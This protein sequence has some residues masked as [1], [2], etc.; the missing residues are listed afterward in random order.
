MEMGKNATH[1][2]RKLLILAPIVALI[3]NSGHVLGCN[4]GLHKRSQPSA[5]PPPGAPNRQLGWGDLNILHTTDS[6]GH[7]KSEQP[8]PNYSG[9][10][11][12]FHSF[13]R[14][15]KEKA[16]Q[17]GVDLLVVDSGD[18][19][20]GNGLSDA[21]PYVHPGT[22]RGSTSSKIF[23]RVPYDIL[24]IG[25]HELYDL[26]IAQDMHDNFAPSWKGSY[27]T[28]NVNITTSGTS[29]PLGSRYRKFV[30]EQGR[31]VTAFGIIFHFTGN[32]N[33]TTVQP[34]SELVSE[35]WFKEAIRD[36]P[37][38]FLLAGHMGIRDP[39]WKIVLDSIRAI[40][41]DVPVTILGGHYHIRDCQQLDDRSM[42]LASGR[43][44]ETLGW[45]SLSGLDNPG[46]KPKFS[47]RYLDANRVTYQFHAGDKFDTIE[48]VQTTQKLTRAAEEF[49]IYHRF[50]VAPH[51]FF[52]YRVPST[53]KE[54]LS[55]L[56]TGPDGVL[57][58]VVKNPKRNNPM[59]GI[60]HTTA[61]RADLY[62]GNFTSN[63][64]FITMPFNNS[65]QYVPDVPRVTA[66][67]ILGILNAGGPVR[68]K[69]QLSRL[70]RHLETK[71]GIPRD[72][73]FHLGHDVTDH[74]LNW[75]RL[76][77]EDHHHQQSVLSGRSSPQIPSTSY[78]YVTKDQ[79]PGYGDDVIHTPLPVVDQT[80]YVAT[81][82]PN[83]S[84]DLIDV[85]FD[86]F[87]AKFVLTALNE[88]R[89]LTISSPT[90]GNKNY[91]ME[92]VE[93]YSPLKTNQ[94]LGIYAQS[95]WNN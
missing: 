59:L 87:T 69:A 34:P 58:T 85:V 88:A 64:Q 47:R 75:M 95:K 32:A 48:G 66:E 73:N 5:T 70:R 63:D 92:D 91:T 35:P 31:K 21:E 45:M 51:S 86:S 61:M 17:K 2:L 68:S 46:K 29:V 53:S 39:D 44:M 18:L 33:G 76:Q 16:S 67:E 8:E 15:M 26:P 52:G 50:G 55:Y 93:E 65:F 42:S 94:I 62:A 36:K 79:C 43:Y 78:G 6:H 9:D 4:D 20:D 81:T 83:D 80:E 11:G 41:P 37:D 1:A 72:Q 13:V 84:S 10:F 22:P 23:T 12:D 89:T 7:L 30:T 74:Y 56:F 14:R 28:S 19:H 82:I 60:V 25:N 90:Q 71:E 27:L 24:A 3:W 49:D 38:L 57:E 54:S 77:F 40:H